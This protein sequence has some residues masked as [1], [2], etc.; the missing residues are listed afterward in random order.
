MCGRFV[1]S[2]SQEI[3]E[4]VF[5]VRVEGEW[6]QR[7]NVA[8]T[9]SV[10]V[11][12][13][14]DGVR[15]LRRMRW[16]FTPSWARPK[17]GPRGG[18]QLPDFINARSESIAEKPSFRDAWKL[19]RCLLPAN[20]FYEWKRVAEGKLPYAIDLP[21]GAPFAMAGV[22]EEWVSPEGEVRVGVCVVTT[23]ACEDMQSVHPRMPVLVHADH[24]ELWLS[25]ATPESLLRGIMAPIPDGILRV[26]AVGDRVNRA[27][28]DDPDL[29]I[30]RQ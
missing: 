8:P 3:I 28:Q 6:E 27:D 7:F 23:Q 17:R 14:R 12:L 10:P 26:Y 13:S 25:G 15:V 22:W 19:R 24:H 11:V 20:A 21:D 29:L 2:S 4:E 18:V 5:G 9:Q 1:I 30:P 16:G